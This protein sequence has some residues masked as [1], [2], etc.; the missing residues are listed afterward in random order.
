MYTTELVKK[1]VMGD[2]LA[3]ARMLESSDRL[4]ARMDT[5]RNISRV[6][7][8][9]LDDRGLLRLVHAE[10]SCALDVTMCFFGRFDPASQSVEVIWQMHEGVEL[11]GGHFPLATGPTSQ[12]IRTRKPQLISNWSSN[13]PTVQVQYATDRPALPESTIIVPVTFGGQVAGVLSVQ[14]YEPAAYDEDDV[15]LLEAVAD[16]LAVTLCRSAGVKSS[17]ADAI[18]ASMDDA[19]LVLDTAGRIV[20]LNPAARRLLCTR[21]GGL[22]LGQPIDRAQAEQWPLGSRLI[23]AQLQPVLDLLSDDLSDDGD[24]AQA[25]EVQLTDGD[26]VLRCRASVLRIGNARAGAVMVLRKAS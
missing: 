4:K 8:Q 13:G 21:K 3:K 14:S 2:A 11:P 20:R 9:P 16:L 7:A 22:I 6:L 17:E 10:L 26:E 25:Q 12:A 1:P 15:R 19:M 18:L 24:A 5:L 23:T